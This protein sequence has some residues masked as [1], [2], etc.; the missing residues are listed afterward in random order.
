[1]GPLPILL[2]IAFARGTC[3]HVHVGQLI[4]I[5][6]IYTCTCLHASK[7]ASCIWVWPEVEGA[8]RREERPRVLVHEWM[9]K[10]ICLKL[11]HQTTRIS[12]PQSYQYAYI[13]IH[14]DRHVTESLTR[15]ACVYLDTKYYDINLYNKL[16]RTTTLCVQ[17]KITRNFL[18]FPFLY[19]AYNKQLQ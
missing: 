16:E 1:M 10:F 18:P 6:Y 11:L 19:F 12:Y 4:Y 7:V 8:G 13:H 9:W 3:T 2:D 14:I 17:W 5:T 15:L